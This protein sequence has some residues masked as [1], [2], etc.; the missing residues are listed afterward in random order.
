MNRWESDR[1]RENASRTY[2]RATAT[3]R[4]VYR[5]SDVHNCNKPPYDQSVQ[6]G[7]RW[8]CNICNK[9]W[10]VKG[11]DSGFQTDPYPTQIIWVDY[12]AWK[13]GPFP[14]GTK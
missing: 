5:E 12:E 7:D 9:V 13:S 4:W 6:V 14:P 10:R 8:Q 11:F 1:Y 3:G 2:H